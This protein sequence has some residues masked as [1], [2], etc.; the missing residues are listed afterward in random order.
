MSAPPSRRRVVITGIGVI[1]PLGLELSSFWDSLRQGRSGIRHITSFDPSELPVRIG[2]EVVGFDARNYLEKKERK[3]LS[4]MVR[5]FQFA[6]A[7]AQMAL[8]DALVSKSALD[9]VRFGTVFGTAVIPSEM[10]DLGRAGQ[11]CLASGQAR[12]DLHKWGEQGLPLIP[13][14]WMLSHIPN[15]MACHVSILH[16]AQGPNNSITQSDVAGLLAL[17]EACRYIRGDRA[18]IVL[19]G[20][21]DSKLIPI[22]FFRHT[23][24]SPLSHRN[25]APDR[26]SRPFD[27]DRDG[28]VLGE[29]GGVLIVEELEHARRRGA[30]IYA[31]I[32]GYSAAFDPHCDGKGLARAA[33]QA[34]TEAGIRP[35]DIDHINAQGNSTIHGDAFEARA[36]RQVF[37]EPAQARPVFAAKSS[38]GHLGAG[39]SCVEL[40]A[41]LLALQHGLVPATLNYNHPAPECPV[42]VQS[43]PRKVELP[44]TLKLAFTEMGQCAAIVCR[45]WD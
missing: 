17:G 39:A 9:P 20:S 32:T 27:R 26:A 8:E 18:D 35:A 31:E 22:N 12:I 42:R 34:I 43:Q 25:D 13:P 2:A 40:A 7:A 23:L 16:N 10:S 44:H 33:A 11:T 5:T 38:L 6:A 28:W 36:I 1:S 29:G 4:I 19:A 30:R 14:L 41:S 15:M 37:G 21:S 3:R 45:R 24:F